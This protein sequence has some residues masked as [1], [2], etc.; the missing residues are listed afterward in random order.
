MFAYF[1]ESLF[2][3]YKILWY[4]LIAAHQIYSPQ[5]DVAF[6]DKDNHIAIPIRAIPKI[7]EDIL[8]KVDIRGTSISFAVTPPPKRPTSR[9][10]QPEIARTI[11]KVII[12]SF[13]YYGFGLAPNY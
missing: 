3:R 8:G 10:I 7:L 5:V 2:G 13:P 11:D 4:K 12:F 1:Y 6:G 9:A